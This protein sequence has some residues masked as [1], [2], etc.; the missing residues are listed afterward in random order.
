MLYRLMKKQEDG[1]YKFVGYEKHEATYGSGGM[2]RVFHMY[3]LY[4]NSH[5]SCDVIG[6]RN[7]YIPH[8]RKDRYTELDYPDGGK[9]FENDLGRFKSQLTHW[10]LNVVMKYGTWTWQRIDEN[11]EEFSNAGSLFSIVRDKDFEFTGIEGTKLK[12][13]GE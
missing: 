5:F 9:I 8:D 13:K 6:S 12:R 3:H 10:I 1:T 4:I 7:N 2:I 11:G